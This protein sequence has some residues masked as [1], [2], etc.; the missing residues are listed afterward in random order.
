VEE[1]HLYRDGKPTGYEV[2]PKMLET[3]A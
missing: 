3:M 1:Y 2:T